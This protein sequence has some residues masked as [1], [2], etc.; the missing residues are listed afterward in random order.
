MEYRR[1][2]SSIEPCLL[3]Y[4]FR[5]KHIAFKDRI[6]TLEDVSP[7]TAFFSERPNRM[8]GQIRNDLFLKQW[9]EGKN[10]F[11]SDPPNA[12]LTVFNEGTRPTGVTVVLTNP[13]VAGKNFLYDARILKRSP[14]AAGIE[15]TLFIDGGGAPCDPQIDTGDLAIPAGRNKRLPQP[16]VDNS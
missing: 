13:R 11:K 12:F 15:S 7:V 5:C 3:R 6:L 1:C 2:L 9:T 8:V 14:P 4:E 10:S 16:R